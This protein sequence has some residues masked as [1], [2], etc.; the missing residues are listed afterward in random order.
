MRNKITLL[1][2]ATV[3]QVLLVS[4]SLGA[5]KEHKQLKLV[6]KYTYNSPITS[7]AF[8]PDGKPKVVCTE[9]E[10]SIY[11][12]NK[13]PIGKQK[14]NEHKDG[15]E[16]ASVSENGECIGIVTTHG[17]GT[18]KYQYQN[19]NGSKMFK[20]ESGSIQN[21][22]SPNGEYIIFSS[23]GACEARI[24]DK[25]G[26]LI[27]KVSPNI[28]SQEFSVKT[29]FSKDSRLCWILFSYNENGTEKT[30]IYLMDTVKWEIIKEENM[31]VQ[32]HQS[33]ISGNG[34][35]CIVLCSRISEKGKHTNTIYIIS[36]NNTKTVNANVY[37]D[38]SYDEINKRIFTAYNKMINNEN[39]LFVAE[40][41]LD[42]NNKSDTNILSSL[43]INILRSIV[44][45]I[46]RVELENDSVIF[47]S[48][49][50]ET[51]KAK[52][53]DYLLVN[54][55]NNSFCRKLSSDREYIDLDG[56]KITRI[57]NVNTL[58]IAKSLI[59][60]CEKNINIYE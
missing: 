56:S 40:Y 4:F 11:G 41:D 5:A 15:R 17:M 10:I 13:K 38:I 60:I 12:E 48:F 46:K 33:V 6:K 30:K 53:S 16:I 57:N 52:W 35:Y 28:A 44:S 3:V 37:Q 42:G 7:V 29:L 54:N 14:I 49:A 26:R 59:I 25:Y 31:P 20:I 47:C 34:L 51:T 36:Q 18:E 27:K 8:Y 2:I 39:K 55:G 24:Y 43:K 22:I 19:I 50:A 32:L 58:N 9:K 45:C 23:Y 1:L 21:D